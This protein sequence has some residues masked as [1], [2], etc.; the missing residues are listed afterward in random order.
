MTKKK[1][2]VQTSLDLLTAMGSQVLQYSNYQYVLFV[3][4]LAQGI[5]KLWVFTSSVAGPRWL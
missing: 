5:F 4:I 2:Q 3:A 1:P